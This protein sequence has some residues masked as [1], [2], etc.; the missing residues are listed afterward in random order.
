MSDDEFGEAVASARQILGDLWPLLKPGLWHSTPW[1]RYCEILDAGEINPAG[2]Q[3]GNVYK[4]SF[5]RSV[6]A[7]SLFDFEN[8]SEIHA[9]RNHRT[10]VT[11]LPQRDTA[12]TVCIGL[13][14][15]LLPGRQILA[16]EVEHEVEKLA[17]E[18]KRNHYPRVEACHVGPIP[19]CAF[20]TVLAVSATH[21]YQ[22]E[23]LVG[24]PKALPRLR[25]L[26]ERWGL[27]Q[28]PRG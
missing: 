22:F 7:V 23:T 8:S 4:G 25:E 11:H 26:A 1:E 19:T 14:R 9:L 3:K 20:T 24:G 5:A 28:Q 13:N 27:P 21:P 6:N 18:R 15:D 12:V 10:W 17:M 16:P 2:G